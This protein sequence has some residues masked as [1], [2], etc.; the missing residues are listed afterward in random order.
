MPY[1]TW[2]H[3]IEYLCFNLSWN[4]GFSKRL[5][6]L[7]LLYQTLV[8]SILCLN[9]LTSNFWGHITLHIVVLVAIYSAFVGLNAT[10]YCFLP[11]QGTIPDP[12][13][14]QYLEVL[15]LSTELPTQSAFVYRH[16]LTSSLRVYFNPYLIVLRTYLKMCLVVVQ[17]TLFGSTMN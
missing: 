16:S 17:C 11:H 5:I 7:W 14:K 4:I 1:G 6:Q 15:F 9:K 12:M 8:A 13:L 10:N 3:G 2:W